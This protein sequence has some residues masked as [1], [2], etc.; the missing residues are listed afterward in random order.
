M[1]SVVVQG[2]VLGI[3]LK[4]L[5][6]LTFFPYTKPTTT[7]TINLRLLINYIMLHTTI[8]HNKDQGDERLF[9]G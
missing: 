8:G 2:E 1:G 6:K 3:I 5:I 4:H 7:F 9:A